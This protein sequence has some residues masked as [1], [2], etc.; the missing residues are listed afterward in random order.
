MTSVLDE[1][2]PGPRTKPRPPAA[3]T[4]APGVPAF[5]DAPPDR[6]GQK[7]RALRG[8]GLPLRRQ[9]RLAERA[10]EAR[11]VDGRTM[12]RWISGED[13]IPQTAWELIKLMVR[14]KAMTGEMP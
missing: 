7:D 14:W 10:R 8:G 2:C 11:R 1:P 9:V 6:M 4:P 5:P 3:Q 13:P 12:R